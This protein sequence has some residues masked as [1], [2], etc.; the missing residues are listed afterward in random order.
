MTGKVK[1][2]GGDTSGRVKG[3]R[4]GIVSGLVS[5]DPVRMGYDGVRAAVAVL[6]HQGSAKN[7]N[8]GAVVVTKSNLNNP[9]VRQFITPRCASA[10]QVDIG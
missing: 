2:L 10:G 4:E 7:E 5:Q 3:V 1:I 9:K 8:T 6:R